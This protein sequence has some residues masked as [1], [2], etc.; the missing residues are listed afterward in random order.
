MLQKLRFSGEVDGALQISA[1]MRVCQKCQPNVTKV[2]KVTP[3][4][5]F[6]DRIRL[7]E[8]IGEGK[9]NKFKERSTLLPK[10]NP[11]LQA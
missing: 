11:T 7:T 8:N 1:G 6:F 5:H 2:T 9:I 3:I 10:P 4:R